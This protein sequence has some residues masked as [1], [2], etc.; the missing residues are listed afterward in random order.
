MSGINAKSFDPFGVLEGMAPAEDNPPPESEEE[1]D[2]VGRFQRMFEA[3]EVAQSQRVINENLYLSATM[4]DQYLA[5]DPATG[6]IYRVLD[7]A[8]SQYVAQNNQMIGVHLALWG[9]LTRS[10]PDFNVTAGSDSQAEA[11]GAVAAERY[12]EYYRTARNTKG[13]IDAAKGDASWSTRG[14]L[15][16]LSWDPNG[17][18]DFYHCFTCGF[19]SDED[20]KD[21]MPCPHCEMQYE[22]YQAQISQLNPSVPGQTPPPLPGTP[23]QQGQDQLPPSAPPIGKL[24]C[25]NRGGP[26]IQDTDPRNVFYQPGVTK[27][28]NMQWYIVREALPVQII[29]FMFP[30][31]ALEIKPESDVYPNHGAQWSIDVE[32]S[33][34]T[35]EALNDHAYLYR[36]VEAPSGLHPNGRVVFMCNERIIGETPGFYKYFGRLPLFRFGWIPIRG[37][38]FYRTP[39]AD[40]FPRQR[41]LNRVETQ[42]SEHTSISSK[43]KTV[44]PYGSR[45]AVDELT[46]QSNQILYPTLAT[47]NYVRY[48]L[49]PQLSQDV[50]NRREML[51]QDIRG[52]YAVT[53]QETAAAADPNGR[54]AAIAEAESDQTVG[55]IIRAHNYE[56][57]DMMRCLL[58]LVQIAGDPEEKF[59]ALGSKNQ[60]L[61]LFQDI[62]F[63]SRGSNVGI[64][65]SDGMSSNAAIRQQQADTK[66]QLGLFIDPLSGQIDKEQYAKAAG[67]KIPGLISTRNS[68]EVLAANAAIAQL[69]DGYPYEPRI[70]DDAQVFTDVIYEWLQDYGRLY[71]STNPQWVQNVSD[72]WMYYQQKLFQ[73]K[74]AMAASAAPQEPGGGKPASNSSGGQSAPGGSPNNAVPPDGPSGNAEQI[75]KNADRQG[76]AAVRGLQKHEG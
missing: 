27:F 64:Q 75:K 8:Q 34:F 40:A 49:P 16:E 29:R 7:S 28:E 53:V 14:G 15:V 23:V 54:Y 17:G 12:I 52:V 1:L 66:L 35:T 72:L 36:L 68:K 51:S 6:V 63:K 46:S 48:L 61:F 26:V 47:A 24:E 56:E 38:P 37:T 45:I 33:S 18:S 21:D 39:A 19:S 20:L 58:I 25:L 62:K 57:A 76:E 69:K 43:P 22:Q 50:Y 4:G 71:E 10:Q 31:L 67:L 9:K 13:T 11:Y 60:G 30:H 5:T 55:P 44:I 41:E 42:I 65:P 3:A 70:Y 74:Q 32:T 73:Q 59:F 2:V